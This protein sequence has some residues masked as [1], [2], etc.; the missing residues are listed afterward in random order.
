MEDVFVGSLM[1]S[2]VH[3]IS[4]DATLR[5]AA[6]LLLDHDIGVAV[7]VDEHG[8]LDGILT[9]TDFVRVVADG[10]YDYDPGTNVSVAMSRDVVTVAATDTVEEAADQMV[11]SGHYHLPVVDAENVVIG[12]ITTH[13]LTAYVSTV[14]AP[15][16]P[17]RGGA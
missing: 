4:G 11:E 10:A 9:T 8:H 17:S 16:P 13:D 6:T 12:I 5:E 2:P 7:V 3:T 15:S 14:R 1:S